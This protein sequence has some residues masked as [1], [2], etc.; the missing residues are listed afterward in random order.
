LSPLF[1]R[2]AADEAL[3]E[4]DLAQIAAMIRELRK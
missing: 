3:D 2:L 4:D 1:A